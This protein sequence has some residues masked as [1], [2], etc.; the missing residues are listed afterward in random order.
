MTL[1]RN[2]TSRVGGFRLFR[3]DAAGGTAVEFALLA[4]P[5]FALITATL[6][7]GI[8]LAT[9]FTLQNRAQ[10]AGRLIRTGQ[11]TQ[12]QDFITAFCTDAPLLRNCAT[13]LH[14]YVGNGANFSLLNTSLPS[15]ENVG[16]QTGAFAT[17]TA[18]Q[19]V[20]VIV[21]YDWNFMFPALRVFSNLPGG[22]ARRLQGIAVF[23]SEKSS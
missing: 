7:M 16:P 14:V 9:E 18:G 21:T 23:R 1:I 10:D 12:Q 2:R 8:M 20:G 15:S 5:L 6:E 22:K 13:N 3:R 11:V 4:A 19:A 17:G